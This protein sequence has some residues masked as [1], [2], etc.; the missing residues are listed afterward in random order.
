MVND[1]LIWGEIDRWISTGGAHLIYSLEKNRF[2]T[3]R[4]NKKRFVS[5][6]IYRYNNRLQN[7]YWIFVR[8]LK[9]NGI[10]SDIIIA[11]FLPIHHKWNSIQLLNIGFNTNPLLHPVIFISMVIFNQMALDIQLIPGHTSQY[12]IK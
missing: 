3:H 4:Y 1:I 8:K 12:P 11:T 2:N 7:R 5:R 6:F 10:I 9:F